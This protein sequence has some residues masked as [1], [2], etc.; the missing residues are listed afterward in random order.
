MKTQTTAVTSACALALAAHSLRAEPHPSAPASETPVR[1]ATN[2]SPVAPPADYFEFR[3]NWDSWMQRNSQRTPLTNETK[4]IVLA[5]RA[6]ERAIHFLPEERVKSIERGLAE[7]KVAGCDAGT[8]VA[9]RAHPSGYYNLILRYPITSTNFTPV[10]ANSTITSALAGLKTLRLEGAVRGSNIDFHTQRVGEATFYGVDLKIYAPTRMLQFTQRQLSAPSQHTKE[11]RLQTILNATYAVQDGSPQLLLS[12]GLENLAALATPTNNST[13]GSDREQQI[14][15]SLAA[16]HQAAQDRARNAQLGGALRVVSET[17]AQS[18]EH[19]LSTICLALALELSPHTTDMLRQFGESHAA[20]KDIDDVELPKTIRSLVD[21]YHAMTKDVPS[22]AAIQ[23][24][25]ARISSVEVPSPVMI[26]CNVET[27]IGAATAAEADRASIQLTS[28]YNHVQRN[29]C[30]QSEVSAK[31]AAASASEAIQEHARSTYMP[32]TTLP[33]VSARLGCRLTDCDSRVFLAGTALWS[34][35][36]DGKMAIEQIIIA[37]EKAGLNDLAHT[38]LKITDAKGGVVFFDPSRI[39]RGD[40]IQE[41][42]A[43]NSF[44][45][46]AYAGST[47]IRR[48]STPLG[49][50]A[51]QFAYDHLLEHVLLELREYLPALLTSGLERNEFIFQNPQYEVADRRLRAFGAALGKDAP[52]TKALADGTAEDIRTHWSDWLRDAGLVK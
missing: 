1:A 46:A 3:G 8:V 38:Y 36:Q 51:A 35:L 33:G 10:E 23:A 13:A 27:Q 52:Q 14:S 12:Q 19:T 30:K 26:L 50:D 48:T 41:G 21:K 25:H 6:F 40:A 37:P 29:F 4:T 16:V 44:F 45:D 24:A 2:S 34:L 43:G 11:G 32:S 22:E 31:E 18:S 5:L 15:S 7:L 28:V 17:Y 20:A 9:N 49:N 39:E 42:D 47:K